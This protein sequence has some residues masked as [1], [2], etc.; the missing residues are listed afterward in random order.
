MAHH[1]NR[2]RFNS[3]FCVMAATTLSPID[4]LTFVGFFAIVIGVSL[5]QSR[6]EDSTAD[7]FLAG[8]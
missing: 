8:R 4:I 1:E 2:L 6:K 3:H 5:Y 7:Y